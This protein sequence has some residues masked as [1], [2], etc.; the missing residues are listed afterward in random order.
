MRFDVEKTVQVLNYLAEK[1]GGSINYTKALKLI[2]FADKLYIRR[3]GRLITWDSYSAMKNGP[4]ASA[5]YN[6]IKSP[7]DYNKSNIDKYIRKSNKDIVSLQPTDTSFLA[8]NECKILDEI[9]EYFGDKDFSYLWE[10]THLYSEWKKHKWVE[11][12]QS[13]TPMSV[14]DFFEDSL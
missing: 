1:E 7:D 14:R 5:T 13:S 6:I 11:R 4:V 8:E 2:F 9:Y 12:L 10:R 3:F